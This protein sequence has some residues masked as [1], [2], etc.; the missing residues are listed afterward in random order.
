MFILFGC[1]GTTTRAYT[2]RLD[3][4]RVE[5]VRVDLGRAFATAIIAVFVAVSW[6]AGMLPGNSVSRAQ[7]QDQ[8]NARVQKYVPA[9]GLL[10]DSAAGLVRVPDVPAFCKAWQ[11]TNLG[12]LIEDPIMQPFL[13]A[14]KGKAKVKLESLE[15]RIGLRF[16]DIYAIASGEAVMAWLPFKND[17]RPFSLV[18]IADIRGRQKQ[19]KDA[20]AK[21]DQDLKA[22]QWVLS[23]TSHGDQTILVYDR[24]PRPGQL[25]IEQIAISHNAIRIIAAD[26][27]SVVM[28]LIDAVAADGADSPISKQADFRSVLSRSA[29]AIQEI[30][31]NAGG[32]I[33]AEWFAKPFQMGRIARESMDVDQGN[34]IDF[35][36]LLQSQGFDAVKA[37]GGIAVIGGQMFDV[38]HRGYVL[39][40]ATADQPDLY[41][42][43]AKMLQFP[44]TA[45]ADIPAW[46]DESTST[47]SRLNWKMENGFWAA[48]SLVNEALNEDLFREII[49]GIRDDEEGPQIDIPGKVLPALDDQILLL[50]DSVDE[51]DID[52]ERMLV[53]IRVSDVKA[54]EDNIRRWMDGEPDA[55]EMD[56]PKELEGMRMWRVERSGETEEDFGADLFDDFAEEDM[57]EPAPLLDQWAISLVEEGPNSSAA[58]LMLSSHPELLLDVAKRVRG[59]LNTQALSDLPGVKNVSEMIQAMSGDQP[60]I[61]FDHVGR[62]THSLRV[63]YEL[64]RRGK[65]KDS[66]SIIATIIRRI[67]QANEDDELEGIDA[68]LLPSFDQIKGFLP[69]GGGVIENSEDGWLMTGFFLK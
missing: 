18:A 17:R 37:A 6:L 63:K 29:K 44:G 36:R 28:D 60:S 67:L 68:Q 24:K 41:Q 32:A 27:K 69:P 14:Q 9:I 38:I 58:Y 62:P 15:K 43:A 59:L 5:T 35:L 20:L 61:C 12:R 22:D 16:E 56:V 21:I 57:D 10:P 26:R 66:D 25:K 39:A 64:L 65:L 19:V 31:G 47:F 3:R 33:A 48:E 2:N 11:T 34:Q 50:T 52:S 13:D 45:L 51:V 1:R 23:E 54:M 49:D 4:S 55:T 46:I 40:P 42:K 30:D 7:G 8:P 53:A